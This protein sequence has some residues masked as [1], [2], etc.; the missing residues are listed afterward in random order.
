VTIILTT[1]Y[2]EQM[3]ELSHRIGI[4]AN[5]KLR[6]VGTVAELMEQTGTSK[7]EDAFVI[8]SGG[9]A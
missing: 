5:G 7:L 8:L 1:H 4:M 9:A 3:E 2:L 6:A